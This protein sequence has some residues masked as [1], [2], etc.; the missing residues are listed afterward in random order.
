[1]TRIFYGRMSTRHFDFDA[2]GESEKAV[3]ATLRDG[4]R[5]HQQQTGATYAFRELDVTIR[6]LTI[7]VCYRD[8]SAVN[9][10]EL[11]DAK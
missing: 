1:M 10:K 5:I 7:G 9:P 8:H 2:V 11:T 3:R 4:W 6:E